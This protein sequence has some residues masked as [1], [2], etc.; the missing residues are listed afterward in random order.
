MALPVALSPQGPAATA[1]PSSPPLHAFSYSHLP[2]P[3]PPAVC[4][5]HTHTQTRQSGLQKRKAAGLTLQEAK[6]RPQLWPSLKMG[7]G[8]LGHHSSAQPRRSPPATAPPRH[9]SEKKA[10]LPLAATARPCLKRIF[11]KPKVVSISSCFVSG[12]R[13]HSQ[14]LVSQWNQKGP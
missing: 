8:S 13:E 9:W 2:P 3:P 12:E 1:L 10:V 6:G 7:L 5:W 14:L 11:E 4:L